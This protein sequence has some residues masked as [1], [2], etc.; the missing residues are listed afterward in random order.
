MVTFAVSHAAAGDHGAHPP[1]R[2][3]RGGDLTVEASL[4]LN[5]S[6]LNVT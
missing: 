6:M 4:K 5:V 3:K 1:S 2:G